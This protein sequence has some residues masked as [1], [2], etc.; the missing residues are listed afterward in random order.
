LAISNE[1]L[2]TPA[3][4][5][6]EPQPVEMREL[7]L[8]FASPDGLLLAP[9]SRQVRYSGHTVDT[10]RAIVEALVEGP[11][12]LLTP[13]LPPSTQVYAVY[14]LDDGELVVDFSIELVSRQKRSAS[15]EALMAYGLANTLTQSGVAGAEG[16]PVRSVRILVEGASPEQSFPGQ[17]H[18]D[19]SRP[20]APDPLWLL[21]PEPP[22][23]SHG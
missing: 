20:I 23:S 11:R 7:V 4:A 16:G 9:E 22:V 19:L 3:P 8:Y 14:L 21:P 17:G 15:A 1:P 18:L 10:C 2:P 5:I 12:E 6:V 13:I